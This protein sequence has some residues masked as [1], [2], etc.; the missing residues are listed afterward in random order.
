MSF[1]SEIII[2]KIFSDA[3]PFYNYNIKK[4]YRLTLASVYD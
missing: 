2:N 3:I 1:N 4:I